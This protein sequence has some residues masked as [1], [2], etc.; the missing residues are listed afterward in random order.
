MSLQVEDDLELPHQDD[1]FI[2][3]S[4]KGCS[5]HTSH[6]KPQANE[7]AKSLRN[8]SDPILKDMIYTKSQGLLQMANKRETQEFIYNSMCKLENAVILIEQG[9][10]TQAE[11]LQYL[12]KMHAAENMPT[13]QSKTSSANSYNHSKKRRKKKENQ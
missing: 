4:T 10:M 12:G 6:V 13:N 5:I 2:Y 11:Q 8:L 1:G 3:L 9:S 7:Q